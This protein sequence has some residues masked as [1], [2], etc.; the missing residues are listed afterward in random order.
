MLAWIA[1]QETARVKHSSGYIVEPSRPMP[2]TRTNN[3]NTNNNN[4]NN[5]NNN[6]CVPPEGGR[7]SSGGLPPPILGGEGSG[8]SYSVLTHSQLSRPMRSRTPHMHGARTA[9]ANTQTWKLIPNS[10]YVWGWVG[11]SP[12]RGERNVAEV[13]LAERAR[14]GPCSGVSGSPK[15]GWTLECFFNSFFFQ[16]D[17]NRGTILCSR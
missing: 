16:R 12:P 1:L 10:K 5:N 6:H 13:G 4:N 3:N 8:S 15:Q 7:P 9:G 14:R 17:P 2:P 11:H